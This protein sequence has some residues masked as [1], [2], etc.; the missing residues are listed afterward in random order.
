MRLVLLYTPKRFEMLFP[1]FEKTSPS[2]DVKKTLQESF[3]SGHKSQVSQTWVPC[4]TTFARSNQRIVSSWMWS[5]EPSRKIEEVS[6]KSCGKRKLRFSNLEMPIPSVSLL[7]IH[8]CSFSKDVVFF[9]LGISEFDLLCNMFLA[10]FK[11]CHFEK[12]L[13]SNKITKNQVLP[14]VT[15]S[16]GASDLHLCDQSRSLGRS[17]TT[18]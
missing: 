13:R 10:I 6:K 7:W 8:F 17:W 4:Q 9:V 12:I 11:N 5:Q 3:I 14:L 15:F 2:I 16:K 18:S 1:S